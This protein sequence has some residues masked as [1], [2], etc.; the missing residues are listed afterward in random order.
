MKVLLV[1]GSPHQHGCTFT[2]LEEIAKTLS[3]EGI[4]SDFFWIGNKPIAGCTA[5]GSC[6]ATGKCVIS[7]D[8]VEEFVNKSK[9]Y[10]GFV[11]GS[12]VHFASVTGAMTTF[13]DRALFSVKKDKPFAGKPAATV[14][15]CRRAG[16]TA[17]LDQLNKYI[18][19]SGMPMV[20]SQYW[21][22]VHGSKPEEVRQDLEGMQ[23]MRTLALNM[24]WMLK[25]FE[26]GKKA[27]IALPKYESPVR[28]NFIR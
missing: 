28:T 20:P 5:C 4:E 6:L 22:M 7:D 12:P 1:N 21:N 2:A 16:S 27:G 13:M 8:I 23:T 24:A 18:V 17:T 3:K 26:A 14:V 9:D 11:F 15:S 19:Y 25:C 10:S